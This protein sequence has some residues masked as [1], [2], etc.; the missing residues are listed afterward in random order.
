M[1][2]ANH[3]AVLRIERSEPLHI[4]E[5]IAELL[6]QLECRRG[7]A[8]SAMGLSRSGVGDWNPPAEKYRQP[9]R[10]DKSLVVRS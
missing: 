3:V 8:A 7:L 4:S 5:V 9:A 2:P 1:K 6:P 10:L